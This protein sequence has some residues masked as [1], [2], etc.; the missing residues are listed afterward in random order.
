MPTSS[1]TEKK[2]QKLWCERGE[3]HWDR[4][5]VRGKRPKS[6]PDHK[7]VL[8]PEHLSKMQDGRMLKAKAER[9]R[10]IGDILS[11]KRCSCGIEPSMD[12]SELRALYPGCCHPQYICP[13]LDSVMRAVYTPTYE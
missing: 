2:T 10:K 8:T 4:I 7:P 3:H 6:C 5:S 13:A 12:D 1:T 9:E 11:G